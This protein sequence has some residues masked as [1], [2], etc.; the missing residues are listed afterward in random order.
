MSIVVDAADGTDVTFTEV[1]S[2]IPGTRKFRVTGD[3][4]ETE[5]GILF[6]YT[7]R[8]QPGKGVNRRRI[9]IFQFVQDGESGEVH[10]ASL[11]V[12]LIIPP[13]GG[14][15]NTISK[16][17]SSFLCDILRGG[18]AGDF[19]NVGS[20]YEGVVPEGDFAA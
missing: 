11:T 19:S 20:I 14:S 9:H 13:K 1:V 10:K 4:P 5:R 18:D 3:T 6:Q 17:M 16:N 8:T 12:E 2:S 15:Y 7:E